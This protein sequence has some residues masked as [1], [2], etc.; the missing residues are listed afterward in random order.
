MSLNSARFK[1]TMRKREVNLNKVRKREIVEVLDSEEEDDN[2]EEI[3]N[4]C[5]EV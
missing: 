3:S 2:I 5:S 4:D 1:N